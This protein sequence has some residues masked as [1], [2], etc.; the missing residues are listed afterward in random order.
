MYD[1]NRLE[2]P[3]GKGVVRVVKHAP[4]QRHVTLHGVG[5]K[6]VDAHYVV[7]GAV[8]GFHRRVRLAHRPFGLRRIDG[9]DP[10]DRLTFGWVHQTFDLSSAK[11]LRKPMTPAA[12]MPDEATP[13]VR[14]SAATMS[15]VIA[16]LV[17]GNALAFDLHAILVGAIALVALIA[18][19]LGHPWSRIVESMGAGVSRA[20]PALF[21]FLMI[22]MLV[23]SWMVS[24][25]IAT[26][27]HFGLAAVSPHWFLPMGL[28]ACAVVSLGTGTAWGTVGT[29]GVALIGVGDGL[30]LPSGMTAGMVVSG[31]TFGDKLS[32]VSDTTN[33]AAASSGASLHEHIRGMLSTTLPVFL[34]CGVLFGLLGSQ[35]A[36]ADYD[37]ARIEAVQRITRDQF[38]VHWA[39]LSPMALV[40]LLSVRRVAPIPAMAA[41]VALALCLAVAV[42]GASVANALEALNRG[43]VANTGDEKVDALLTR[44]GVQS[45]MWTFSLAVL[46]L[47]LGGLLERLGILRVLVTAVLGGVR[48]VGTLVAATVGTGFLT[49]LVVGEAYLSIVLTGRLFQ[50]AFR[51]WGLADRMLS[52]S[53]EDGATL[54]TSLVPWTTAGAFMAG[55]LGVATVDYAPWAL[56]NWLNPLL[57]IGLAYAGWAVFRRGRTVSEPEN[58]T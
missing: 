24:G 9:G 3:Q 21:I 26:L 2:K 40:L 31:A 5:P 46:A 44:G 22:G 8:R 14:V 29:L 51:R 4:I 52:R 55:A 18:V 25:T 32:P 56:F 15:L 34:V 30:G 41:G 12:K 39:L 45:M 27:L 28:L 50:P 35:A 16:L 53:L 47:G 42:Q 7:D 1:A 58:D 19:G 43:Y 54:T 10:G 33:L 48:R 11:P 13:S 6:A 17:A 37:A 38:V 57:S 49:N 36:A 20:M 23:G